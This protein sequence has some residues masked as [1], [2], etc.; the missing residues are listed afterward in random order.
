MEK[1]LDKDEWG[2]FEEAP[3]DEWGAFEEANDDE[4]GGFEAGEPEKKRRKLGI[5]GQLGTGALEGTRL[6]IAGRAITTFIKGAAR[7]VFAEEMES[8]LFNKY[9]YGLEMPELSKEKFEEDLGQQIKRS[10]LTVSGLLERGGL[11]T[12]PEGVAEEAARGAG[13]GG[14]VGGVGGAVAGAVIPSAMK[15]LNL[16]PEIE[17]IAGDAFNV[18]MQY[19]AMKR[20][21]KKVKAA[22]PEMPNA[23]EHV[24]RSVFKND[25]EA[26]KPVVEALEAK[27]A[28]LIKEQ[29]QEKRGEVQ[30]KID[31]VNQRQIDAFEKKRAAAEKKA[32]DAHIKE[33]QQQEKADYAKARQVNEQEFDQAL[34]TMF[35]N[36][37]LK[38]TLQ[39]GK[40]IAAAVR[41]E[42]DKAH[43]SV[44]E[45][46]SKAVREQKNISDQ[47]VSLAEPIGEF[48][49]QYKKFPESTLSSAQKK[50]VAF[51]KGI[52]HMISKDTVITNADLIR[53]EQSINN[54]MKYD[55]KPHPTGVFT[56]IKRA[57]TDEL[58][59]TSSGEAYEAYKNAKKLNA[60]WEEKFGNEIVEPWRDRSRREHDVMAKR[61]LKTASHLE[62][63]AE[64]LPPDMIKPLMKNAIKEA[65]E[66]SL[67]K[68]DIEGYE[69]ALRNISDALPPEAQMLLKEFTPK[70][71]P[72]SRAEYAPFTYEHPE[73]PPKGLSMG[74]EKSIKAV[75]ENPEQ[76]LKKLYTIS[77]IKELEGELGKNAP[78]LAAAKQH[79]AQQLLSSGKLP[80]LATFEDF[81]KVVSDTNKRSILEH[82]TDKETVSKLDT[83][84]KEV[85]TFEAELA[86][87]KYTAEQKAIFRQSVGTMAI[88]LA[89]GGFDV[90]YLAKALVVVKKA[91]EAV[92]AKKNLKKVKENTKP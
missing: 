48:L 26:G 87:T 38:S 92:R 39:I 73:K 64:A 77:G 63:I 53:L 86:K 18:A 60:E 21:P 23:P 37:P 89:A 33:V 66:G 19:Q 14:K 36:E 30:Q 7:N 61:S 74:K 29:L 22:E 41:Q 79:A 25:Y 62:A 27:R 6:A 71:M 15:A 1:S 20:A 50:A 42:A 81:K 75:K 65:L 16:P 11:D 91:H 67:K 17:E 76:M 35:P 78:E 45:A 10:P 80:E 9:A 24:P 84:I 59:R 28:P 85:E 44:N 3:S 57:I 56:P 34:E 55:V 5:A 2:D 70:E 58:K 4:W 54:V 88:A 32:Y 82:L 40:D 43:T 12:E 51:A 83:L 49:E 72:P 69:T 13:F 47:R 68:G 8:D 46:Y 31:I 90:H 52:D